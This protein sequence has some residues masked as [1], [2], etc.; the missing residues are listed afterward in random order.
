MEFKEV[1]RLPILFRPPPDSDMFL[2]LCIGKLL[3][4]CVLS[5]NSGDIS[6]GKS[7]SSLQTHQYSSR[8]FIKNVMP[9]FIIFHLIRENDDNSP[10]NL[11]IPPVQ[12]MCD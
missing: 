5:T 2:R 10:E 8:F 7:S 11:I 1:T 3:V 4:L 12:Y 6:S 9:H